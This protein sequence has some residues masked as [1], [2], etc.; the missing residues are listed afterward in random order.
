MIIITNYSSESQQFVTS[1]SHEQLTDMFHKGAAMSA[2]YP[3]MDSDMQK[4]SWIAEPSALKSIAKYCDEHG[5][6]FLSVNFAPHT[7]H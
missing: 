3:D 4:I 2:T 5:H 7:F 6:L 1:L